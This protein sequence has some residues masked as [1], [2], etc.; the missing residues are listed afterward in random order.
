[1]AF[2][3]C[4]NYVN[5]MPNVNKIIRA[6]RTLEFIVALE[7][8]MN[9]TARCAD[10]IL[11]TTTFMERED[12]TPGVGVPYY[13]LQQTAIQPLGECKTQHEIAKELAARLGITAYDET[14]KDYLK[15]LTRRARIPD[16]E[17]FRK[18]GIYRVKLAEPCVAFRSQIRDPRNNPFSTPSGKIEIYSQ[19]IADMGNPLLPPIPTYLETWESPGDPLARR[20]PIQL[21]TNHCKRRAL[22]KWDNIP[23][24]R[25]L[26]PQE[27]TISTADAND[28][29]IESGDVVRVFNDRGEVRVPACVTD[30]IMPGVAILPSGAWYD[31]DDKGVDRGGCANVLTN[32]EPS[33]GGAFTYNTCLI[34]IEKPV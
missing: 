9:P 31:P 27:I 8:F 26:M 14:E 7:Q 12:I 17:A 28:R 3:D 19:Q 10:I 11:P 18:T 33:P 16:Y 24:L 1:M 23:W 32:D 13:G 15:E 2:A 22:A 30:R 20:Y 6:L 29:G 34:Q 4:T 21:I 5:S 25:E